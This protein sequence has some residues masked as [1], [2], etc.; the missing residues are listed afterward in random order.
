MNRSRLVGGIVATSLGV[1][2]GPLAPPPMSASAETRASAHRATTRTVISLVVHGCDDCRIQPV[3]NRNGG[4]PWSGRGGVVREDAVTLDVPTRRTAQMAF[5]VYAPFDDLAQGGV[6][7]VVA[8]GFKNKDTGATVTSRY[9]EG[10]HQASGCWRGTSSARIRRTLTVTQHREYDPIGRR[11]VT[12]A[13]GY[14]TRTLS[15]GPYWTST[16]NAEIHASDPSICR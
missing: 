16:A 2:A 9:A 3:Q 11:R 6:P 13:A 12:V 1:A 15:A 7:M 8:I 5:V 14:F 4:I 10:T